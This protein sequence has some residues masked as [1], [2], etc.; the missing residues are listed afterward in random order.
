MGERTISVLTVDD[1]SKALDMYAHAL[2]Q[3]AYRCIKSASGHEALDRLAGDMVDV[4]V[5][6]LSMP[7]MSG[8]EFI[9]RVR[10]RD[11]DLPILVVTGSPAVGSA[12]ESIDAGVF[13]YL[14]KP[15]SP[16]ALVRAVSDAVHARALAIARRAAHAHLRGSRPAPTDDVVQKALDASWLAVQPIV[17]PSTRRVVAY[18]ALFRSRDLSFRDPPTLF[19]AAEKLDILPLVGRAIRARAGDLIGMLP[20]NTD[21]FLNLHAKDLLD[22]QL[23]ASANPLHASAHRVVLELSERRSL[24]DIPDL[25]ARVE[26]LKIVGYRVALDDMGAGYAGLATFAMLKPSF[27]KIDTSLVRDVDTEPMKQTLIKSILGLSHELGIE[28]IAEGVETKA[29]SQALA[30][31]GCTLFQGY[32]FSRPGAPFPAVS[33]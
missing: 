15:L 20:A 32:A 1:D 4:V 19:E 26:E 9:R 29:E 31:L 16:S 11:P 10:E 21:L 12:I 14:T 17:S 25:R 30:A 13:R 18:E 8:L 7:G 2:T 27:V 5:S 33:W 24:E 3:A 6:D 28:G 23:F 22:E